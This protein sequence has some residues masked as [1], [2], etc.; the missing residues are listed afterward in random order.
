MTWT[1]GDITDLF[2]IDSFLEG[3]D[4]LIHTAGIVSYQRQ[5]MNA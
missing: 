4:V 2:T 1:Q 3:V 5:G